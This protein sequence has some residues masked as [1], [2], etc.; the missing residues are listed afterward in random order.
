MTPNPTRQFT[1]AQ[2]SRL[3]RF[4]VAA[5]V[6]LHCHILPEVDDGPPSID[7]ALTLA[8]ALVRDGV[9]DVVATPHQMGRY[10]GRNQPAV[11]RQKV[12]ELQAVLDS[13]A[14]PLKLHPGGE[15]RLDQR[16]FRLAADDLV[17]TVADRGLH[18]LVELPPVLEITAAAVMSRAPR[19]PRVILAHAERYEFLVDEPSRAQ[20]WVECGTILQVNAGGVTGETGVRAQHAVLEWLRNGWVSLV[21]SDAHSVGK[22]RP[23][24]TEAIDWIAHNVSEAV[25]A[26]VCG[27]NPLRILNG[28]DPMSGELLSDESPPLPFV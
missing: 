25:A 9:T 13:H 4:S 20:E 8:R 10:E 2:R 15:V 6:D 3:A 7:E 11:V 24:L 26:R 18:I 22:R 19:S 1:P 27:V 14:I 21:A 28:Q 5:S 12:G 16:V 17:A 23:R